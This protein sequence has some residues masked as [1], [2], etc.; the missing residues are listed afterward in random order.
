M[1]LYTKKQ[2]QIERSKGLILSDVEN[3]SYNS[4]GSLNLPKWTIKKMTAGE[5]EEWLAP[6]NWTDEVKLQHR[7]QF[8]GIIMFNAEG[9]FRYQ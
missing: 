5:F 6:K 3:D 7:K 1:P 2:L 4:D 8:N 9:D